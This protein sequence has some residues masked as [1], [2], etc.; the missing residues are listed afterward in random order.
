MVSLRALV[1]QILAYKQAHIGTQA[2]GVAES[3]KSSSKAARQESE[4]A[5]IS[6]N[7]LFPPRKPQKRI[8]QLIFTGN[9]NFGSSDFS[10][11]LKIFFITT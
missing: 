1:L 4:P 8:S 3:A 6:A 9:M 5:L 11:K 2:R 7:L 10:G